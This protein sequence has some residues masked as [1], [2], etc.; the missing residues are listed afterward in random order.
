MRAQRPLAQGT[1]LDPPEAHNVT[2][3]QTHDIYRVIFL[4]VK[5]FVG[6]YHVY[7]CRVL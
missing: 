2:A 7:T 3:E 6:I 4:N 1:T 5:K